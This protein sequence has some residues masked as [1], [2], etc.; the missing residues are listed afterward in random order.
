MPNLSKAVDFF[1][2]FGFTGGGNILVFFSGYIGF[3]DFFESECCCRVFTVFF[4]LFDY[5]NTVIDRGFYTFIDLGFYSILGFYKILGFYITF[6]DLG[7]YKILG[8]YNTFIDLCFYNILDFYNT[9]IELG[10]Y[11]T[12]FGLPLRLRRGVSVCLYYSSSNLT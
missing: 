11:N 1:L 8:F 12:V 9:F 10:F 4:L 2:N 7:F 6:I 3:G 5:Y